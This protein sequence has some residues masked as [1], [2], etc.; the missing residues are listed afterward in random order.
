MNGGVAAPVRTTR[1]ARSRSDARARW[2]RALRCCASALLVAAFTAEGQGTVP[3]NGPASPA[4]QATHA[5]ISR[6][7][8]VL[9]E[10]VTVGQPFRVVVRVRAPRGSTIDF[11]QAPDSGTAVEAL[12]PVD[13]VP[14][15]DT[16]VTEQTATYRLAAWDVGAR[17]IRFADV[18]VRD[19]DEE[20]AIV[21]D[22]R[23]A[24]FV[25]SVL[26]ADSSQRA[27]KPPR[28]LY[29]FGP[30]WWWWTLVA[31]AA[32]AVVGVL[33]W[34][35]RRR[36]GVASVARRSP[37]EEA[38][39]EFARIEALDLVASGERGQ[40]AAL[41]TEVLRNYLA[42]VVPVA[43]PSLT[44]TELLLRLRGEGRVPLARLTR[45]LQDVDLVKF[46]GAATDAPR[47]ITIGEESQAIVDSVDTAI[48]QALQRLDVRE[49]A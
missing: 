3:A 1:D 24:V 22:R 35:W 2:T 49:A 38:E 40:H 27:P 28:A 26:P 47:A 17:A 31:L 30:P 41:M 5:A 15:A 45:V 16:T 12:D 25:A 18:V 36:R 10:T 46:A 34:L 13:V 8:L 32:V 11:P 33:W 37:R 42:R 43:A 23:L 44:T 6:G 7:V 21:V 39:A 19:G 20:H 14:S 48:A 29:E 9:P 4:T